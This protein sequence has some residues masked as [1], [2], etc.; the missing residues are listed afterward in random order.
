[1]ASANVLAAQSMADLL[2][3]RPDSQS[4]NSSIAILNSYYPPVAGRGDGGGGVFFWNPN[5]AV[6][7]DDGGTILAPKV[8]TGNGC[9][10]RIMTDHWNV[11]WFGARGDDTSDD[12]AA[13]QLAFDRA[14]AAS[15]PG[16]Q[17]PRI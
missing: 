14:A 2:N 12:L 11:K 4:A 9:W 17:G 13:F 7:N 16:S 6:A 10:K 8:G 3:Q 1:M 15:G 5:E